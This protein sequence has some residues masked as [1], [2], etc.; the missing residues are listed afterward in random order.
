MSD[1]GR[2]QDIME[3]YRLWEHEPNP[4]HRETIME[5]IKSIKNESGIIKSM[6]EA[7]VKAHRNSDKW[8][9]KNIHDF[10]KGKSKYQNG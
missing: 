4:K 10:I 3:L 9:I 5:T 1:T 7:L 8:E 2:Q 6:R